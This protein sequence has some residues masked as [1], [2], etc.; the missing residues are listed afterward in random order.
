MS[1]TFWA[2]SGVGLCDEEIKNHINLDR[3]AHFLAGYLENDDI[4]SKEL[5]KLGTNWWDS[6]GYESLADLLMDCDDTCSLT[7]RGDGEGVFYL[8]YP[9]QMPWN[10]RANEPKTLDEARMRI[11]H[12]IQKIADMDTDEILDLIDNDLNVIGHSS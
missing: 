2:I 5:S 1:Q 3:A 6:L 9:K 11:V 10:W 8:F 7:W 12:T 4:T